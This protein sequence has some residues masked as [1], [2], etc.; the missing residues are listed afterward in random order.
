M[1]DTEDTDDVD[2]P[3]PTPDAATVTIKGT[4]ISITRQVDEATMSSIIALLFGGA[5]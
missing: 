2:E 5:R 4:S 1:T 3:T